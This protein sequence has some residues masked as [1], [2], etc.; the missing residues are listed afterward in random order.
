MCPPHPHLDPTGLH[1]GD[2]VDP[3]VDL[4]D[5]DQR[6]ELIGHPLALPAIA[7]G[8][9]LGASARYGLELAWPHA[10]GELPWATFTT[11]ASGCL[12]LG[13]VMVVVTEVGR[14]HPLWRPFLG[15]GVLGGFTT[16]STYAVQAQQ[17]ITHEASALALA[18]LF[19]TLAA[20]LAAVTLGTVAAR[21][22]LGHFD[23]RRPPPRSTQTSVVEDG[24]AEDADQ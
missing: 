23:G 13:V 17:A 21:T 3:D 15:V 9:A 16:F 10:P 1:R 24:H 11:N 19:G 4:H 6:S 2:P 12:L 5:A 20:A 8:G 18:Y 22:V 14:R 7:A